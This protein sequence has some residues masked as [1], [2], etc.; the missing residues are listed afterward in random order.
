MDQYNL[1]LRMFN[2]HSYEAADKPQVIPQGKGK[3]LPGKA[4]SL[5]I[6]CRNFPLLIKSFVKD[7]DDD[8]FKLALLLVEVTNRV[9]AVEVM[10]YEIEVLENLISRKP[11]SQVTLE[12]YLA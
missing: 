11:D 3:K 10:N 7:T 9:A 5:W 4:I 1:R 2:F 8:V 12:I 6:H